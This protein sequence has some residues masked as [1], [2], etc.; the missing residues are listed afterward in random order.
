ICY[1]RTLH[2]N[3]PQLASMLAASFQDLHLDQQEKQQLRAVLMDLPAD[4]KRFVRNQAFELVRNTLRANPGDGLGA[5]RWL[6]QISKTLDAPSAADGI[7]SSAHFS[8]GDACR[9]TILDL[10]HQARSQVD[11]CIFTLSD[12]RI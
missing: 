11:I 1:R 12:D 10:L 2:L 4:L 3:Q 9:T 5:F 8:P 7:P 6:E